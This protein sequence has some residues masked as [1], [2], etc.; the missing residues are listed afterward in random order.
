MAEPNSPQPPQPLAQAPVPVPVPVPVGADRLTGQLVHLPAA[1]PRRPLPDAI[2]IR[3]ITIPQAVPPYDPD[4]T[5]TVDPPWPA[6]TPWPTSSSPWSVA[7]QPEATARPEKT[8]PAATARPEAARPKA[9]PL[10]PTAEVA[11]WPTAEVAAAAAQMHDM[12]CFA[13]RYSAGPWPSQFAQA[14]AETLAGTRPRS[15]LAPWTS[16]KARRRINQLSPVLTTTSQPK[17]KRVIVTSPAYGVLEMT[18]VV[19]IGQRVRALAVRLER[20]DSPKQPSSSPGPAV[21]TRTGP[22]DP[23]RP[24]CKPTTPADPTSSDTAIEPRWRCTAIEAA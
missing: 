14:L 9:T 2:A 4:D 12:P 8:R 3:Q 16:I 13:E 23:T 5:A 7:T 21:S 11:P 6:A 10:P 24:A 18:V 22:A 1:R 19:D 15:Q 20:T 17:L